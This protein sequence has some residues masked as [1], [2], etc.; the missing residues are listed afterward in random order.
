[1]CFLPLC[2]M[3]SLIL[4]SLLTVLWQLWVRHSA[5][6]IYVPLSHES[7]NSALLM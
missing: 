2:L 6:K 1:M 3:G 7:V 5:K 4:V